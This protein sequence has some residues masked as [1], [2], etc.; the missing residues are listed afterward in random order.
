MIMFKIN[1][2]NQPLIDKLTNIFLNKF[3]SCC[4]NGLLD[5]I[6]DRI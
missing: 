5:G 1:S 2:T 6:V 3:A 4:G